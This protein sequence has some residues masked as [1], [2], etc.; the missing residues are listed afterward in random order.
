ML[1]AVVVCSVFLLLRHASSTKLRP[2]LEILCLALLKHLRTCVAAEEGGER[3]GRE[4]EGRGITFSD[5]NL[6]LGEISLGWKTAEERGL[7]N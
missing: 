3:G 4:R 7:L 2:L 5:E 1:Y 6:F